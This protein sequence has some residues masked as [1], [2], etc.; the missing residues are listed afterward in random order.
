MTP[1]LI[2]Y[3]QS[4]ID[5][6]KTVCIKLGVSLYTIFVLFIISVQSY[7]FTMLKQYIDI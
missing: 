4:S 1:Q 5:R 3:S 2:I 7:M 6:W